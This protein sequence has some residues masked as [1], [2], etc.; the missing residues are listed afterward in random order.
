[1][2]TG[3]VQ[4]LRLRAEARTGL[5]GAVVV[6]ALIAAIAMAAAFVFF[7]F[8]VFIWLAE[9]Y[10]PLTA[11][12]IVA[13]AFV[14]VAIICAIGA[15]MAQRRTSERARRALAVRSQS[16]WLDPATL[17]IALQL[18]RSIGLRRIAPLAAA[19]VLAAAL[20]KEWFR[21]RPDDAETR[22]EEAA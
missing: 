22:D 5:S 19:G 11:A 17:G 10:S 14:L 13:V 4:N 8:A 21:D 12:L 15:V 1:M 2:L 3:L 6:F 18:G 20:A 7:V 9:R 16:P